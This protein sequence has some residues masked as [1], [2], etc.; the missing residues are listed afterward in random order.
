[1]FR[2]DIE[3]IAEGATTKARYLDESPTGY[4]ILSGLAGIYLGFGIT[5][6]FSVGAPFAASGS[7]AFKLVMG[8]AFGIALGLVIFAGS[9]DD[10]AEAL[11]LCAA[12]PN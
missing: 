10:L 7:P 6:I 3:R 11:R 2:P 4:F 9:D 1:M 8:A 12:T 5:L